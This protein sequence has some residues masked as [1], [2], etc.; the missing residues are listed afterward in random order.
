MYPPAL[1]SLIQHFE[2]LTEAERRDELIAL[3]ET[4]DRYRPADGERFDLEDVRKDTECSD[5]VGIH[6]RLEPGNH[7]RLAISLGCKVQTLTRALAVVL[8]RGLAD[9]SPAQIAALTDDFIVR[10][11]GQQLVQL[12]ARTIYYLLRR[13]Q[14]AA[15]ALDWRSGHLDLFQRRPAGEG[16]V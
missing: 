5:M 14:E 15:R 4:V 2:S 3:A 12:R 1:L 13:V 6:L 11:V 10:I 9:A 7:L 16:G 8:C